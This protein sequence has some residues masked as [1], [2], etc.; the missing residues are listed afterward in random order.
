MEGETARMV[1]KDLTD[2]MATKSAALK[3]EQKVFKQKN[4]ACESFNE[5]TLAYQDSFA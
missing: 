2:I 1:T 3:S 5:H 4:C